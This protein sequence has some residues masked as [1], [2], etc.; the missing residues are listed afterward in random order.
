[1]LIPLITMKSGNAL[2][3]LLSGISL[4]TSII[5]LDC[6]II[7]ENNR[8]AVSQSTIVHTCAEVDYKHVP[9]ISISLLDL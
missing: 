3:L 5:V 2:E 9:Y 7:I 4:N 6:M 1:M 8:W